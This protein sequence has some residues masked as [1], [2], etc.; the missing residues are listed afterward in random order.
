MSI[1]EI[2]DW[3]WDMG[4]ILIHNFKQL[5]KYGVGENQKFINLLKDKWS[6]LNG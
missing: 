6:V 1:E 4:N 3:Y 2:D 5:Q